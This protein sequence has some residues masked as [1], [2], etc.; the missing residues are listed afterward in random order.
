MKVI[1]FQTA[2]HPAASLTLKVELLSLSCMF[3]FPLVNV[4]REM[5]PLPVDWIRR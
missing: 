2:N 1:K 4:I 3:P 5:N